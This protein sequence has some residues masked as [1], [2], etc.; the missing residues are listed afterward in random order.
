MAEEAKEGEEGKKGG[1]L[2]WVLIGVGALVMIGASVFGTLMFVNKSEP[3]VVVQEEESNPKAIYFA[4]NPN[5]QTNYQVNRRQRLFRIALTLVTRDS[6]V[7]GVLSQHAPAIRNKVVILLG[8]QQFE[9][10]QTPDGRESLREQLLV[11]IQ[12]ILQAEINKPGIERVLFT[13]F[14]M[15]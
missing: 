1:M 7:V 4:I 6:S 3:E 9:D 5:F 10:L 14:V 11:G 8:G 13:D 2:R 12:E 15:Q